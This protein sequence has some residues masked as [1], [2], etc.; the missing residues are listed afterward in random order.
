MWVTHTDGDPEV[1]LLCGQSVRELVDKI[2][3]EGVAI[4]EGNLIKGPDSKIDLSK[5]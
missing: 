2:G 4:F 1:R 3:Q 5:L